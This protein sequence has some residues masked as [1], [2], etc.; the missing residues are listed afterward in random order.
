MSGGPHTPPVTDAAIEAA[1]SVLGVVRAVNRD[2]L[3]IALEAAAPHMAPAPESL[4]LPIEPGSVV[5]ATR[6]EGVEIDPPVLV[7]LTDDRDDTPWLAMQANA[8]GARWIAPADITEWIPARVVPDD[9]HGPVAV[10]RRVAEQLKGRSRE[11]LADDV[12]DALIV[13]GV[14]LERV[15]GDL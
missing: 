7:A 14:C 3:R 2:Y 1:A 5:L 9:E 15:D 10:L 8:A 13:I 11:D 6:I 12:S 4:A